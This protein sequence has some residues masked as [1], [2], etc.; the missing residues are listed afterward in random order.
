MEKQNNPLVTI[1]CLCYNHEQFVQNCLDSLIVQTYSN[2]ELIII[3][4][5]STDNSVSIINKNYLSLLSKFHN[6]K[7]IKN[8]YNFGITKA[9]NSAAKIATGEFISYIST[10]D[11]YVPDKIK[12]QINAFK[13]LNDNYAV[14][15]GDCDIIDQH[16]NKVFLTKDGQISQN[17]YNGFATG[18]KIIL[19]NR[20]VN[21]IMEAYGEYNTLLSSNYIQAAS[22]LIRKKV[23]DEVGLF[24]EH[25]FYEDW[26][27][28][29]NIAKKYNFYYINKVFFHYRK[30]STVTSLNYRDK[31]KIEKT[32]ILLREKNFCL[33]NNY[34][35]V[36][37]DI[38]TDSLISFILKRKYLIFIIFTIKALSFSIL[39]FLLKKAFV[40]FKK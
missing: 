3:D 28:W 12:V 1:I 36:W 40:K 16:N 24:D 23:L 26:P 31:L 8:S 21:N 2:L 4:N 15:C 38:Y 22:V 25:F 5:F 13:N 27:L 37:V 33:K 6:Y 34:K 7:F 32:K 14:V 20:Q 39:Y 10:D 11:V 35:T 18:T 29:L 19:R 30:H 9:L 17:D